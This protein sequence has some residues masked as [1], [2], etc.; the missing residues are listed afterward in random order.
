MITKQFSLHPIISLNVETAK[1]LAVLSKE[2]ES[3]IFIEYKGSCVN[4]TSIMEVALLDVPSKTNLVLKAHGEDAFEA[5]FSIG[6]QLEKG[7][8]G[9]EIFK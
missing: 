4:I 9:V 6:A 5:I 2:F 3:K 1:K 7:Y 8:I